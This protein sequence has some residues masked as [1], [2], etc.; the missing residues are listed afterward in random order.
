MLNNAE[1]ANGCNTLKKEYEKIKHRVN[2]SSFTGKKLEELLIKEMELF[3]HPRLEIMSR[4]GEISSR[5][6]SEEKA[7]HQTEVKKSGL[8]DLFKEAP[9]YNHIITKP[10][11]YPGD[12]EMMNIIYRN[13]FEGKTPF[14][15]FL[16]K[17]AVLSQACQAVRNRRKLMQNQILNLTKGK[18][19]SLGAGPATEIHDVI[20]K[21]PD[22]SYQFHA[23]DQDIKALRMALNTINDDRL[24][25]SIVNALKI[26]Q[27]N[28]TF[29]IR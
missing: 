24:E 11:G 13:S 23:L 8:I 28:Y 1:F 18:I 22:N 9:F 19:F 3:E 26:M 5:F 20:N 15:K 12:A 25:Y 10:E 17:H 14:A 16:H 2:T 21:V 4:L 27:G 29:A 6:T 7:L